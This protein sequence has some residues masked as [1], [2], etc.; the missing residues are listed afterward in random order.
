MK[1]K[2]LN[3]VNL[4]KQLEDLLVPRLRLSQPPVRKAVRQ[5]LDRGVLR[6][7]QSRSHGGGAAP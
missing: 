3:A 7:I 1:N 5:L 2:K 6:M 4:W